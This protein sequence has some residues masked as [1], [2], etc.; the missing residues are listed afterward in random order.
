MRSDRAVEYRYVAKRVGIVLSGHSHANVFLFYAISVLFCMLM[1]CEFVVLAQRLMNGE[2][3]PRE[4]TIAPQ[5]DDFPATLKVD[6]TDAL[7]S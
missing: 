7:P 2:R 4:S 5:G 6:A 3:F 1:A